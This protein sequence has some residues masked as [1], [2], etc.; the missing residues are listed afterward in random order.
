[1]S[2]NKYA[3]KV[4]GVVDRA[5]G[6]TSEPKLVGHPALVRTVLKIRG[7]KPA[8]DKNA[9]V[10]KWRSES[11]QLASILTNSA[12]AVRRKFEDQLQAIGE[13]AINGGTATTYTRD[14]LE[15][16]SHVYF[17]AVKFKLKNLNRENFALA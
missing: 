17:E 14:E 7:W 12:S 15:R 9:G 13:A 4:L 1:M 10:I 2:V 8:K 16:R 6:V 5:L 11:N 3:D